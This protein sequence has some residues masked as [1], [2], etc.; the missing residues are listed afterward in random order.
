MNFSD[1]T[2][3]ACFLHCPQLS[4][5]WLSLQA[6]RVRAS[7][8]K[9]SVFSLGLATR[10]SQA[11]QKTNIAALIFT[12]AIATFN[13]IITIVDQDKFVLSV[14][15]TQTAMTVVRTCPTISGISG[16]NVMDIP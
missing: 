16:I 11:L 15:T 1:I 10:G 6:A 14:A 5:N 4:L 3:G 12:F 8:Q 2:E 9:C 7:K 13:A